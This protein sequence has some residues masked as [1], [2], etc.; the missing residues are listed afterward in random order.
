MGLY[1]D[2]IPSSGSSSQTT[3]PAPQQPGG[4]MFSDLVPGKQSTPISGSSGSSLFSDLVPKQGSTPTP[5][6]IQVKDLKG[7]GSYNLDPNNPQRVV[8]TGH[9]TYGGEPKV[10][11]MERDDIV[12]V[13]LGGTNN[14][15]NNIEYQPYQETTSAGTHLPGPAVYKDN[16]EK[17]YAQQVKQGNVTTD[18]ARVK[19][20]DWQNTDIPGQTAYNKRLGGADNPVTL[21]M[22]SIPGAV[23]NLGQPAVDFVKNLYQSS[24]IPDI[25]HGVQTGDWSGYQ[26]KLSQS[27]FSKDTIDSA[28]SGD[29]VAQ[30]KLMGGIMGFLGPEG[31]AAGAEESA[32]K[33]ASNLS[34]NLVGKETSAPAP[35]TTAESPQAVQAQPEPLQPSPA[36][37][38]KTTTSSPKTNTAINLEHLDISPESKSLLSDIQKDISPAVSDKIGQPMSNKEIED[39]AKANPNIVANQ[40]TR[41]ASLKYNA[42]LYNARQKL[43]HL[44]QNGGSNEDIIRAYM[45][46]KTS[47]TDLAR[48]LQSLKMNASPD[49]ATTLTKMLNDILKTGANIDDVI[50][51]AKDVNFNDY[52]QAANFYRQY[53]KPTAGDWVDLVRYNSMLSSPRTLSNI[54][55][56]NAFNTSVVAP[57]VK[58]TAGAF[59]WMYSTLTRTQQTHFMS[60]GP[61][62]A[63]AYFSAVGDAASKFS[64]VLKGNLDPKMLDFNVPI[65][66]EGNTGTF[67]KVMNIFSTLHNAMYTFFNTMAKA[68]ESAALDVKAAQGVETPLADSVAQAGADYS[69][70]R[71]GMHAE[72]QGHVL[73]AIDNITGLVKQ[74]RMSSNP[75]TSW[76][77]KLTF[78]FMT[79][80]NNM[81]KQMFEYSPAGFTTMWGAGDPTTQFA[82]AFLGT[83]AFAAIASMAS[84]GNI[85]GPEPTVAADKNAFLAAGRQAYSIKI[86]N[87]WVSYQKFPPMFSVPMAMA[88]AYTEAQSNNTKAQGTLDDALQA[89]AG[90]WHFFV[91]ASYVKNMGDLWAAVQGDTTHGDP[92]STLITNNVQQLIPFRAFST[93]LAQITDPEQRQIDNS[94]GAVQKQIQNIMMQFPGA[95]E[96]LPARKDSAGNPIPN[97][98]AENPLLSTAIS[99]SKEN[100]QGENVFNQMQGINKI[101]QQQ[102]A[103]TKANKSAAQQKWDELKTVGENN[104]QQATQQLQQ[105]QQTDPT[106]ANEVIKIGKKEQAGLNAADTKIKTL[107]IASGAR[108]QYIYEQ[109]AALSDDSARNQYIQ[110]LDTKKLL[111]TGKNRDTLIAQ[112]AQ[113]IKQKQ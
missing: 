90:G 91:D 19:V 78:P 7:G 9:T 68:G 31:G 56:D 108:A 44:S 92:I 58:S 13:S 95:R 74:A 21:F 54:S 48:G 45:Q 28:M 42:A 5:S 103:S 75:V 66:T 17:Y 67:V 60:E 37:E 35:E 83:S 12:P 26:T 87:T 14:D 101:R 113:L 82:K 61:A 109:A 52:N 55:I 57:L 36:T 25:I 6:P 32:A 104:P 4:S 10:S 64:D 8:N 102:T 59:D 29:K 24:A 40:V 110:S 46:V 106:L 22:K 111:G 23:E 98:S 84:T 30:Q 100:P 112:L 11:G 88:A 96:M 20:L 69:T 65:A 73:N 51:A 53:I 94:K 97:P 15:P 2:L 79:I 18:E 62:Y 70:F 86:G 76:T 50:A 16:I 47:G 43:A 72:G 3:A 107:G 80:A 63:K 41:D 1:D 89:L 93:W 105:L 49:E 71:Q 77:A 27:P 99:T 81:A 38:V 85:T 33:E 39:F 34:E